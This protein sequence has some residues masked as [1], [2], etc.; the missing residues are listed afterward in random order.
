[1]N[2]EANVDAALNLEWHNVA[3]AGLLIVMNAFVCV[4]LHVIAHKCSFQLSYS[5]QLGVVKQILIS[6]LRC[7][8]QMIIL[9]SVLDSVFKATQIWSVLAM[10]C[11][12]LNWC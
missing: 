5:L 4:F 12:L 10:A 6:A 8:I 7:V 11:K 3:I 2:G 1:M 9:A